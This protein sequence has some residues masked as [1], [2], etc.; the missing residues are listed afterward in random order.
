MI[1]VPNATVIKASPNHDREMAGGESANSQDKGLKNEGF[2]ASLGDVFTLPNGGERYID[3]HRRDGACVLLHHERRGK[4]D[5]RGLMPMAGG[6]TTG[7]SA[8]NNKPH[9]W[10]DGR[11]NRQASTYDIHKQFGFFPHPPLLRCCSLPSSV[12]AS[13]MEAQVWKTRTLC[14]NGDG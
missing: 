5:R 10:A 12:W 13:Y 14:G 8:V 3:A 4:R 1:W 7:L 2:A 11:T 9:S 6:T